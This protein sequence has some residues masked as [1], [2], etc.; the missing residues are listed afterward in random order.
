MMKSFSAVLLLCAVLGTSANRANGAQQPVELFNGKDMSGWV[1]MFGGE[2][3]VEDGILVGRNGTNWTTNPAL[4]GSWLRTEQQY[5]DFELEVEYSISKGG[6]SGIHFRS[7]LE[8][9]PSFTG[10][11]MQILDDAGREARKSGSGSVYDVAA[12]LKNMAKP[13]GEWNVAKITC[14]GHHIQVV[15]NGEKIIDQTG[16][17]NLRGYIG[18]QNHD[19]KSVVRFRKVHLTPL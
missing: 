17:R 3:T 9:N 12:P 14:K 16:D 8:R 4:S 10:Y 7:G 11:E 2:W 5:G 13:S 18:L 1:Q 19:A 6:N 15:L